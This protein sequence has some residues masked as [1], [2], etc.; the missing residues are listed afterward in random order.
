MGWIY[1]PS[2]SIQNGSNIVTVT[3]T[4]TDSI[5][6]GD[7]LLI[8][9]YDLVEIIEV[10]IGQLKLK[11]NW[12][13]A[14][15][16]NAESAVVPT[17]GDFNAATAALRQATTIT[18]GNFAEMEK[19][20]T[21]D[22]WVT[23]KAYNNTEHTV[24]TA[25]QM[26]Q[27]VSALEVQANALIAEIAGAGYARSE[28]DMIADRERNNQLYAASGPIHAGKHRND[29]NPLYGRPIQNGLW[30]YL[31]NANVLRW[32][33][34][35]GLTS[36]EGDSKTYEAVLNIAGVT[37]H[38]KGLNSAYENAQLTLPPSPKGTEVADSA[39]GT[40][41]NF[42]TEIDPKYGDVASDTNEAVERAF[43]GHVAIPQSNFE[44]AC[45]DTIV[46]RSSVEW[47]TDS[48]SAA[49][50]RLPVYGIKAGVSYVLEFTV[51]CEKAISTIGF[52]GITNWYSLFQHNVEI[53]AGLDTKTRVS[54]TLPAPTADLDDGTKIGI[55]YNTTGVRKI[56]D[57]SLRAITE[58]VVISPVDLVAIEFFLRPI[59]A[60]DPFVYGYGMQQSKLTS[61]DGIPT[62]ENNLRPITHFAVY[63]GEITSRGRG[64]NLLDGSLSD[65]QQAKILQNPEHNIYRMND[66]TLVQ[67]TV[68][69]RTIRGAGNGDFLS[70]FPTGNVSDTLLFY[71]AKQVGVRGNSDS[72]PD[73]FSNSVGVWYSSSHPSAVNDQ[74]GVFK[75]GRANAVVPSAGVNGECYLYVVTTVPR[76]NQGAY[77]QSNSHGTRRW[78]GKNGDGSLYNNY[79]HAVK[80][81]TLREAF[82]NGDVLGA[83]AGGFTTGTGLIGGAS[84]H[85]KGLFFDAIYSSGLGGVVDQR[86]K[87]GAWD[88]SSSEQ[89]AV[90]KKEVN[91]GVYRGKERLTRWMI[92][93]GVPSGSS[94][95]LYI[96]A[97]F[98]IKSGET[99]LS[100][101][102]TLNLG[103]KAWVYI[104]DSGDTT[105]SGVVAGTWYVCTAYSRNYQGQVALVNPV[106]GS[107]T[108]ITAGT[109][110][111]MTIIIGIDVATNLT[112]EDDFYYLN[113]IGTPAEIFECYALKNGWPGGWVSDLP[114]NTSKLHYF[115]RPHVGDS[116]VSR[117]YTDD[118]GDTW[119]TGSGAIDAVNQAWLETIPESRVT[120]M[121][122]TAKAGQTK[123]SSNVAVCNAES[124][125]GRFIDVSSSADVN[126]GAMLGYSLFNFTLKGSDPDT[127]RQRL[128]LT[129]VSL[130]YQGFLSS[131]DNGLQ[132][133]K[134][135][136]VGALDSSNDTLA[137]KVMMHQTSRSGL[138]SLNIV[139][140]SLRFDA[141]NADWRDDSKLKVKNASFTDLANVN[142][143]AVIHE[144]SNPYGFIKNKN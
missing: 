99:Y 34:Y 137:Y 110:S 116:T 50:C 101:K 112:V 74:I 144:L 125:I 38:L 48:H 117:V 5:K 136:P 64:F 143:L 75:A 106:T 98:S 97:G 123:P 107:N 33:A 65:A 62:V 93:E 25:K 102:S 114:D 2:V 22:G 9:S 92:S 129:E 77:S 126:Y 23:F 90:V 30:T 37:V 4:A 89:A 67:W 79:W 87:Y 138:A 119:L 141:V 36:V 40:V 127:A 45:Y 15:Q 53:P 86:L 14:S 124:G 8:G 108:W 31:N 111:S 32:G 128:A 82:L 46:D 84:G 81:R 63:P 27:D 83:N 19:W 28:S 10:S 95:N 66:G 11:K 94:S 71:A 91:N 61:V 60:A 49:A 130:D 85:P 113:V 7:G 73:Y 26:E 100:A 118:S 109:T 43:E 131:G 103:Y 59:T 18:Q 13:F 120:L 115:S 52:L 132:C 16:S 39:L 68:S 29:V 122:L 78:N 105:L 44:S 135:A 76:A 56:E 12:S 88:A 140:N 51:S 134:H 42:E 80:N 139:A 70:P 57:I 6:P 72:S 20:W 3:N 133:Q 1:L 121:L 41:T 21:Q 24:R 69:Q 55:L 17:F 104:V 58:E 35:P 142:C 96:G 47:S 54:V